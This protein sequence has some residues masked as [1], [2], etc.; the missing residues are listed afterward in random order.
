MSERNWLTVQGL[1][2]ILQEDTNP[3][4]KVVFDVS[5]VANDQDCAYF[6]DIKWNGELIIELR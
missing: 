1:I 4:D 2:E 5:R 6:C 3:T